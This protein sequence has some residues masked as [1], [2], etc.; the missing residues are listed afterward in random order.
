MK[1]YC[2]KLFLISADIS[3]IFFNLSTTSLI[4]GRLS[5]SPSQ[6]SK[7]KKKKKNYFLG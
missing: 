6:H 1:N 2:N 3:A 5:G 7:K 4:F